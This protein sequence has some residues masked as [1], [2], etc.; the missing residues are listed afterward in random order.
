VRILGT[1][2]GG[3]RVSVGPITTP[4]LPWVILGRALL[5]HRLIAERNHAV[6]EALVLDATT[7]AHLADAIDTSARK[8]MATAFK[9][10]RKDGGLSA[11]GRDA[12]IGEIVAIMNTASPQTRQPD[13]HN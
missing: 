8:R 13:S 11:S 7:G 6:R 1:P 9:R 4:N 2:A 12:L 5:H 3:F 10:I